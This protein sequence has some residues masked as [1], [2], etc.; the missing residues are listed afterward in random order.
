M[1]KTPFTIRVLENPTAL[2]SGGKAKTVTFTIANE[3]EADK[4]DISLSDTPQ[5]DWFTLEK[6]R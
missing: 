3:T 2:Q 4:W 5:V 6:K 1:D